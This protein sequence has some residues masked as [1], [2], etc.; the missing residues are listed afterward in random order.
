MNADPLSP[1]QC[2]QLVEVAEL[3][4][5]S[6]VL[7]HRRWLPD[8]GEYPLALVAPRATFVT[9][10]RHGRL[11][12]CIGTLTAAEPLVVAVADR[13]RAAALD[14]PRFA[15]VEAD[16]L[17]E[18]DVSVSV[19]TP[20]E[21]MPVHTYD[22]LVT[23]LRPGIDGLVIAADRYHATFLPAVWNDLPDREQFVAALWR[24]AGIT[25]RAWPPGARASRYTAQHASRT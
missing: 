5:R 2:A 14:D 6:A 18:L 15:G 7:E 20:P 25:P 23:A 11:R 17:D 4:I 10:Q 19:L 24:K 8:P 22:E 21:P 3:A 12:G 1:A 13:A 9:L 16:E